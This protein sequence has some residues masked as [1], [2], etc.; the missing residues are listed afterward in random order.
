M[1]RHVTWERKIERKILQ[2]EVNNLTAVGGSIG[3]TV[4]PFLKV[5]KRSML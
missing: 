1:S 3:E 2:T 5:P 4:D